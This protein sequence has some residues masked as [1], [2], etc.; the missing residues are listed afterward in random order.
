MTRRRFLVRDIAEILERWQ[1]GRSICAISR[2]LSV[3]RPTVR[4]YVYA[5]EARGYHQGDPTPAQG[6]K[7]FLKE[8]IPKPP[9][10]STR[11][12]VFAILLP[13]QDEIRGALATTKPATIWR[14]LCE[15]KKIK[16]SMPSFYRYLSCF[17][18]DVW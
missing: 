7:T 15:D 5:V 11:S 13:Y 1:A 16:V 6:W 10:P 12:E 17:L 2:S 4:K 18:S 14:R 9:D 3:S 8:V